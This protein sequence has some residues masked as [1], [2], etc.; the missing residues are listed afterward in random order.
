MNVGGN[1]WINNDHVTI[2]SDEPHY[3]SIY[4]YFDSVLEFAD[5][6]EISE[7]DLIEATRKFKNLDSDDPIERTEVIDYI[8]SD[9][10]LVNKLTAFYINCYV[11][12]YN[13]AFLNKAQ[14]IFNSI[15]IELF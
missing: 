15:E 4:D 11:D 7:K 10:K 6:L 5:A 8:K 3:M 9:D 2:Y 14:E 13:V 1:S 12:D